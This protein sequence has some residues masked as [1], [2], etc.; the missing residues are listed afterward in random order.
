MTHLFDMLYFRF[1][2]HKIIDQTTAHNITRAKRYISLW[3]HLQHMTISDL[4]KLIGKS[5][6]KNNAFEVSELLAMTT[7]LLQH[8]T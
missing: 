5:S 6:F 7:F 2:L 4:R 8:S 1:N 3:A